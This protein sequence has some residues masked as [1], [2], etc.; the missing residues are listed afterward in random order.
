MIKWHALCGSQIV[1]ISYRHMRQRRDTSEWLNRPVALKTRLLEDIR[2]QR[3]CKHATKFGSSQECGALL[4]N[5]DRY[6][7]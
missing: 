1:K 5:D 6:G 7:S 2:S 3:L 4:S